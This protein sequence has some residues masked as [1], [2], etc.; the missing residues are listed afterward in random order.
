LHG[1]S[2]AAVAVGFVGGLA[3]AAVLLALGLVAGAIG[4]AATMWALVLAPVALVV[5]VPR[6]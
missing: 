2:G 1:G 3:G 5:L 6:R 4:L